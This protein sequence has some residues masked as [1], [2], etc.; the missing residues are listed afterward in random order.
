MRDATDVLK[1]LLA[2]GATGWFEADLFYDNERVHANIPLE[3]PRFRWD[4]NGAIE[5]S[6]TCT[7]VYSS[8]MAESLSPDTVGSVLAPF[9]AELAVYYTVAAGPFQEKVLLGWFRIVDVPSA[10]DETMRF[11]GRTI[12]VG[13]TVDLTLQDRMVTVKRDEFDAPSTPASLASVWAEVARLSGLQVTRTVADAPI[14]REVVYQQDKL[15]AIYDLL[16]ILDATP[17]MTSDG[18]L[19]ARP[20]TPGVPVDALVGGQDGTIVSIGRSLSPGQ[21]YNKVIVTGETDTGEPLMATAEITSGRLRAQNADGSRSPY[22]RATTRYFSK[23]LN[24]QALVQAEA[25]R[26][27]LRVSTLSAVRVPITET[28]TPLRELGDVVTAERGDETLTG[29]VAAISMDDAEAIALELEV[30]RG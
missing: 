23:F 8:E 2:S 10:V 26:R 27:L 9:G 18:T 15:E 19:A 4:A 11:N 22:H 13:S 14:T 29:V 7:I 17:H 28:F 6:G 21:V 5:G 3:R 16:D 20:K 24:T 30:T 12:T 1:N 25:D